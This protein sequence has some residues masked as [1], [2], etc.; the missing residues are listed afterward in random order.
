M[1]QATEQL[2]QIKDMDVKVITAAFGRHANLRQLKNIN[3]GADVL[4]FQVEDKKN[5]KFV[6][7]GL[8]Q[9][10]CSKNIQKYFQKHTYLELA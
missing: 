9:S 8:L 7:M 2:K 10:K 6:G 5:F 4:H 1:E 3:G